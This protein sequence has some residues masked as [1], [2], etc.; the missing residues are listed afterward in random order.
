MKKIRFVWRYVRPYRY[1]FVLILLAA[2]LIISWMI[3]NVIKGVPFDNA[4]LQQL[5]DMAGGMEAL[6]SHLWIG[7]ALVVGSYLMV[8]FAINRRSMHAGNVAE[9][10]ALNVRND[11][12]DHLQKLPFSYHKSRDS[13]DLIQRS[14][15]DIET[16]R[17]F[18]ANQ[19]SEMLF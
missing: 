2:P 13:G 3:D 6:Q 7:S 12:Y 18:L 16:V 9:T 8:A 5:V 17:R 4:F 15:S 14:T 11:L 19:F 1:Q 10:L